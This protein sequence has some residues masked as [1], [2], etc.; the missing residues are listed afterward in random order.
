MHVVPTPPRAL[1]FQLVHFEVSIS[2]RLR[3]T[4]SGEGGQRK[5]ANPVGS[6]ALAV[7]AVKAAMMTDTLASG[8]SAGSPMTSPSPGRVQ[9]V[10]PT[11]GVNM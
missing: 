2:E 11:G 7:A 8:V 6:S 5:R 1:L 10:P 9:V 3:P 4:G